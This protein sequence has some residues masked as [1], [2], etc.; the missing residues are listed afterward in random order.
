MWIKYAKE[1]YNPKLSDIA[2]ENLK[3]AVKDLRRNNKDLSPR[4]IETLANATKA[5]A[6]F[7]LK[8]I[9]D[10]NDAAAIIK[11][12]NIMIRGYSV[13]TIEPRDI[14]DI[15]VEECYKVLA[16]IIVNETIPYTVKELLQNAC[17]KINNYRNILC[18]VLQRINILIEVRIS[19]HVMSMRDY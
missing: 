13:N 16:E 12:Y 15:G 5:R 2:R 8:D 14:L 7:L 19:E 17:N 6:R 4:V 11:F 10:E 18:L 9:A 3:L 1:R